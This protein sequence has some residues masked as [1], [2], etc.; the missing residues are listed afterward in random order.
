LKRFTVLLAFGLAACAAGQGGGQQ[1]GPR[2]RPVAD[3]SA[4]IAAE[5]AFSRMAQEK[6]QWTAFRE[7]AAKGAEM[8]VP[9]RVLAQ[10]WLKGRADPPI[11]VRWQPTEVWSSCDGSYAVTRGAWQR[12]GS[13][14]SF[15]T[16]WQRQNDRGYK[17]VL[18]MS[19]ADEAAVAS[20]DTVTAQVA[21]CQRG[22]REGPQSQPVPL[23]D[24]TGGRSG[25]SDD[26]TLGWSAR[27]DKGARSFTLWIIKDGASRVVLN[28]RLPTQGAR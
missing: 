26:G 2:L 4:V 3:P 11:P 23:Q 13:V 8:F 16:V 22:K 17:W 28:V 24:A 5:I 12:P 1:E 6:G 15:V 10:D 20:S 18:D 27:S 9:D 25:K 14:G 19:L 21:D 7:T